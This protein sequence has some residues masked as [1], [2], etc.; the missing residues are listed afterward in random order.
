MIYLTVHVCAATKTNKIAQVSLFLLGVKTVQASYVK[1]ARAQRN[2]CM[3]MY[4]LGNGLTL[5]NQSSFIAKSQLA[6]HAMVCSGQVLKVVANS[7]AE[8]VQVSYALLM[9][10]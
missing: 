3:W 9:S 8:S 7:V 2:L 4:R 5:R 6:K 1:R 10:D